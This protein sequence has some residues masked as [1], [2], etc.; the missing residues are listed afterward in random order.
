MKTS[1]DHEKLAVYQEAI[2]LV[3]WAGG[4]LDTLPKSLAAYDQL[5]GPR[6]QLL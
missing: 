2:R 4:L 6:R 5:T 3:A 1:F